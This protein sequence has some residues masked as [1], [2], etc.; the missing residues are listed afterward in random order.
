MKMKTR[1]VS[2]TVITTQSKFQPRL[3]QQNTLSQKVFFL[4]L[5]AAKQIKAILNSIIVHHSRLKTILPRIFRERTTAMMKNTM[6]DNCEM[7][8]KYILIGPQMMISWRSS[9]AEKNHPK[10][11]N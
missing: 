6:Q 1:Q 5:K 9:T 8:D 11:R 7:T 3:L 4:L 10:L 2:S